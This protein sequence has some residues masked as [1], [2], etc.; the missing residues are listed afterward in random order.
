VVPRSYQIDAFP[1][2]F[3][4]RNLNALMFRPPLSRLARLQDLLDSTQQSVRVAQHEPIK[5][6]PPFVIDVPALQGFEVKANR[7]DWSL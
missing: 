5:F 3:I 7:G 4:E 6:M 2:Q 1:H